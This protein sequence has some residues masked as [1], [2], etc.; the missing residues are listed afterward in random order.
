M[1]DNIIIHLNLRLR[2][3]K[4]SHTQFP[5]SYHLPIVIVIVTAH[6]FFYHNK[7]RRDTYNYHW[8]QIPPRRVTEA[9]VVTVL[10]DH[11]VGL[12]DHHGGL[13]DHHVGLVG[14]HVGL[15]DHHVGL[16]GHH[17][18]LGGHHV[19]L[20]CHCVDLVFLLSESFHVL[21][22]NKCNTD[23]DLTLF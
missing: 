20:G 2:C 3:T 12:V 11:Y 23:A 5:R 7:L 6:V 19:G 21:W 8:Q 14:H 22:R 9:V 17:V 4:K 18:G 15:V 13:V 1:D 10:V 16:V